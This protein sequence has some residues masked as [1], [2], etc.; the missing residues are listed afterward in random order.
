MKITYND[1]EIT[2]EGTPFELSKFYSM[3]KQVI[4]EKKV[5]NHDDFND[6]A[7]FK[8]NNNIQKKRGRPRKC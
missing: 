1:K 6:F 3:K 5:L 7:R 4:V 8:L 2:V